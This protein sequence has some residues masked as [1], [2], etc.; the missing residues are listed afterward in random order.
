VN[1][2]WLR[3]RKPIEKATLLPRHQMTS[4]VDGINHKP[5]F[6]HVR[7]KLALLSE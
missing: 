4:G 7:R 2:G 6:I 1:E 5:N 3:F